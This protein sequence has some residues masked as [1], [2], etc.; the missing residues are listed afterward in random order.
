MK[1]TRTQ[2]NK[3]TREE[4]IRI[5]EEAEGCRILMTKASKRELVTNV[6]HLDYRGLVK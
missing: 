6:L 4:L 1:Y 2:L 3:K 5:I